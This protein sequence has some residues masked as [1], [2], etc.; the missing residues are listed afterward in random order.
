MKH[1]SIAY[2]EENMLIYG[3]V[4]GDEKIYSYDISEYISVNY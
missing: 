4:S 1:K 2:D 3:L